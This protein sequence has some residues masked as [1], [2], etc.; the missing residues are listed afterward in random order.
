MTSA[1]C[2]GVCKE[3]ADLLPRPLADMVNN[4]QGHVPGQSDRVRLKAG[5]N[6]TGFYKLEKCES[7]RQGT[8]NVKVQGAWEGQAREIGEE[9]PNGQQDARLNE[10]VRGLSCHM[11]PSQ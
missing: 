8:H 3:V 7:W 4:R 10:E 11:V 1:F 5:A 9:A 2:G 6:G